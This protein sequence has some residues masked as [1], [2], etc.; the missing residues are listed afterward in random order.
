MMLVS[1][2]W[3]PLDDVQAMLGD[4]HFDPAVQAHAPRPFRRVVNMS[5]RIL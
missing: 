3:H 5:E 4:V 2:F 1:A